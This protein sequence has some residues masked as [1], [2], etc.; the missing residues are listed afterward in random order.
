MIKH[1]LL[2]VAALFALPASAAAQDLEGTWALQIDDASIFVFFLETDD[3]GNWRGAWLRPLR[4]IGNGVVFSQFRGS[5]IVTT[6][7]STIEGEVLELRFAPTREEGSTDILHFRSTGV[8]QAEMTYLETELLPFPLIRVAAGTP[9]GP[10]SDDRIYDRDN[11]VVEAEYDPANERVTIADAEEEV[12][13]DEPDEPAPE[14]LDLPAEE[15]VEVERGR[16][17]DDFLEG[18][19]EGS[20][21]LN[22]TPT[23]ADTADAIT[24]VCTDLD[25]NN[26]PDAAELA[27]LWGEDYEAIGSGLDIREYRMD[28]GDIARITLLGDRVYVN[29]CGPAD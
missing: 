10:F 6:T 20:S 16:L 25:R 19:G 3:N 17:S 14:P 26:L 11:A 1:L 29:S 24:R 21:A 4:F 22:T 2:F 15:P 18:L 12:P 5:E 7:N 27:A 9:L 8:N 23:A 28:N 13:V